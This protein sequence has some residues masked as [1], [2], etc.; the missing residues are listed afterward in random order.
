MLGQLRELDTPDHPGFLGDLVTDF[1]ARSHREL[2][3]IGGSIASGDAQGAL[4]LAHGLK[5]ASQMVAALRLS[6]AVAGVEVA[7][8]RGDL[9]GAGARLVALRR[10]YDDTCAA[11]RALPAG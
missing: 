2:E 10:L 1:L 6:E 3:E 11:L 4:R 7:L 8:R 9:A 5:G